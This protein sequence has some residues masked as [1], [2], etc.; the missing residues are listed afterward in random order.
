MRSNRR[1]QTAA[2]NKQARFPLDTDA[3]EVAIAG[4]LHQ[5]Q[6]HKRKIVL[7]FN[8]YGSK[9]LTRTHL[10]Y[11]ASKLEIYTVF[12]FIE[13]FHSYLAG[14]EFTLSVDNQALSWLKT[15]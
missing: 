4:I 10:N 14:R 9:S 13:K 12:Y 1:H 5:K 2:T 6:E 11:G 8:V 3:S 7:R 15:Y